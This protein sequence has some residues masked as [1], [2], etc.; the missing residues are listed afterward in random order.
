MRKKYNF[1]FLVFF[2]IGCSNYKTTTR[3]ES[4]ALT[5]PE[6]TASG[7]SIQYVPLPI[8]SQLVDSIGREYLLRYCHGVDTIKKA[9]LSVVVEHSMRESFRLP[10]QSAEFPPS[11]RQNEKIKMESVVSAEMKADSQKIPRQV[12]ESKTEETPNDMQILWS[13]KFFLLM[14]VA[15]GYSIRIVQNITSEKKA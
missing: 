8:T 6:R 14:A 15:L 4:E 3:T 9:G 5:V 13:A 10:L 12:K 7:V 11:F 1:V 2:I